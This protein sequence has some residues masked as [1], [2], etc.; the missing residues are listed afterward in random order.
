MTNGQFIQHLRLGILDY[1]VARE[2][3][4]TNPAATYQTHP[5]LLDHYVSL[6]SMYHDYTEEC[7]ARRRHHYS[8]WISSVHSHSIQEGKGT[9]RTLGGVFESIAS[10][11]LQWEAKCLDAYQLSM[12]E[13]QGG[14]NGTSMVP[15]S[16]VWG[17]RWGCSFDLAMF[18]RGDYYC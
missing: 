17:T 6:Y 8:G 7:F 5:T 15:N 13:H 4:G 9:K 12:E 3:A 1:L 2:A 11:L 18:Q 10:S 14:I 16:N